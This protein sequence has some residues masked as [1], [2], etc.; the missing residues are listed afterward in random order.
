MTTTKAK[1]IGRPP[2]YQYDRFEDGSVYEMVRGRDFSSTL[3]SARMTLYQGAKR[4]GY[5]F[6]SVVMGDDRFRFR[7]LPEKPQD[8][9]DVPKS[10][11]K[12]GAI[13]R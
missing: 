5:Y 1:R 10:K 12:K 2:I 9:T 3:E 6:Q 4:R 8:L 7:F 11:V 13:K